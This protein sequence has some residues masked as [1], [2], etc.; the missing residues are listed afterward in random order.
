MKLPSKKR[1]RLLVLFAV[2]A[3]LLAPLPGINE[4]RTDIDIMTGRV[5]EMYK[6]WF[7]PLW[8]TTKDSELTQVLKPEDLRGVKSKWKPVYWNSLT[9]PL[10]AMHVHTTYHGATWQVRQLHSLWRKMENDGILTEASLD[11]FKR[12]TA[13]DVLLIWQEA[14]SYFL[15]GDYLLGLSKM[16]L[17]WDENDP[18]FETFLTLNVVETKIID[19]KTVKVFYGPDGND[20]NQRKIKQ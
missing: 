9:L 2:L 7:V 13:N 19:G 18:Q 14:G 10:L 4:H 11:E 6:L 17:Y 16:I 15:V 12:K 3:P 8:W 5:R 20:L 1:I